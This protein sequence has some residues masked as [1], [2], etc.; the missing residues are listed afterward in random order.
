[1]GAGG[2]CLGTSENGFHSQL[3]CT[4]APVRT[5]LLRAGP[6]EGGTAKFWCCSGVTATQKVI[7]ELLRG[8]EGRP[9][10]EQGKAS[11]VEFQRGSGYASFEIKRK[12]FVL[13]SC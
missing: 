5:V 3:I 9:I 13:S 8:N 7:Y 11:P 6:M 2:I 4:L 12:G 1:M 10:G